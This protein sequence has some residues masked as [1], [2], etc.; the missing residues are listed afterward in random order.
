MKKISLILLLFIGLLTQSC[1]NN[2]NKSIST[3]VVSNPKSATKTA[4][5]GTLPKMQFDET[6]H[7]FG[8]MIQGERVVYDF[9][10]TNVGGSDLLITRVSTSCGCTVGDYPKEPIAPGKGG[11]IEVTFDSHRK[12]GYQNKSIT[13]L[14]NTKPNSTTLRI[15]A[16]IILPEEK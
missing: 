9:H 2:N 12:R 6:L 8:K 10:F 3:D 5:K 11:T 1:N 14:A 7:D 13:I 15:K 16:K 4:K